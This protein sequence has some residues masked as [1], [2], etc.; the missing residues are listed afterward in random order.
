MTGFSNTEGVDFLQKL[1]PML[2]P[3]RE[4][5][6]S[7]KSTICCINCFP[8]GHL[9]TP[10]R[11]EFEIKIAE[12][13]AESWQDEFLK[14]TANFHRISR[15]SVFCLPRI[16]ILTGVVM[17]QKS[18]SEKITF[19]P[20]L[21]VNCGAITKGR[22][23][24]SALRKP[25][26]GNLGIERKNAARILQTNPFQ[27]SKPSRSP[28]PSGKQDSAEKLA[29]NS[30]PRSSKILHLCGSKQIVSSRRSDFGEER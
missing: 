2:G 16:Q 3:K 28:Y 26:V 24:T 18:H 10:Q 20:T 27:I 11:R 13:K 6:M 17:L 8:I 4:N 5:N 19:S 12:S 9:L 25:K 30:D 29:P 15:L 23:T 22:G 14:A 1:G 7:N 21:P